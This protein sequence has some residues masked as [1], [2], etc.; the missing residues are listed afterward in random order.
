[1]QEFNAEF[2]KYIIFHRGIAEIA[3]KTKYQ[4]DPTTQEYAL[5]ENGNLIPTE[6]DGHLHV[7]YQ[8]GYDQDLGDPFGARAEYEANRAQALVGR[9]LNEL[10]TM[11]EYASQI[12]QLKT[13][14]DILVEQANNAMEKAQ[15]AAAKTENLANI[16]GV[17]GE[18]VIDEDGVRLL[19]DTRYINFANVIGIE[20]TETEDPENPREFYV[21]FSKVDG[22]EKTSDGYIYAV[23]FDTPT[24]QIR[25]VIKDNVEFRSRDENNMTVVETRE[26]FV[27]KIGFHHVDLYDPAI[28]EG[29]YAN[30]TKFENELVIDYSD[31]YDSALTGAR[32]LLNNIPGIRRTDD[33]AWVLDPQR[34]WRMTEEDIN[35]IIG[36]T[37]NT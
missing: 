3:Y 37:E 18:Y 32:T 4:I 34:D 35:A 25:G 6:G 16:H 22:I 8:D 24:S 30:P 14:I 5:D 19:T 28:P 36:W 31:I 2:E 20:K 17:E 7:I 10:D 21:D 11:S 33:G 29:Q 9:A 12:E 13:Q 15:T 27:P 23:D 26:V 1:M